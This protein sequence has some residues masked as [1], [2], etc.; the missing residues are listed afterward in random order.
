M[1]NVKIARPAFS[2]NSKLYPAQYYS[3]P[4]IAPA[5]VQ[6][7][8]GYVQQNL[9]K[10][11]QFTVK[12][13]AISPY[14]INNE[15]YMDRVRAKYG[16]SDDGTYDLYG[17]I[18][19]FIG[20]GVGAAYTLGFVKGPKS[21][22]KGN[23]IGSY[24]PKILATRNARN[25]AMAP[26]SDPNKYNLNTAIAKHKSIVIDY[27]KKVDTLNEAKKILEAKTL[28]LNNAK[29]VYANNV[30]AYENADAAYKSSDFYRSNFKG[31]SIKSKQKIAAVDNLN[32]LNKSIADS[33]Q[34][35]K[36]QADAHDLAIDSVRIAE[37]GTDIARTAL[38][39]ADAIFDSVE[40]GQKIATKSIGFVP[41]VGI[42]MDVLSLGISAMALH[43]SIQD[44]D[45]TGVW[46]NGVA[47]LLDAVALVADFF[48][49]VGD[50]VSIAASVGST[51]MTGY[52]QGRTIGRSFSPEG[53]RAQANFF[54]NIYHSIQTRPIS[55]V[56]ALLVMGGV[57]RVAR[58]G[59]ARHG[60]A[61][62]SWSRF[63]TGTGVGNIVRSST[64]MLAM[65]YMAQ[66]SSWVEEELGM[67]PDEPSQVNF[68]N[69]IGIFG[70]INDNLFGATIRKSQMA[71]ILSGDDKQTFSSF[72]K[73]SWG[74]VGSDD[75][76][77]H[78]IMFADVREAAGIDTK[79]P[80]INSVID[81]VGEML[82][83][84]QNYVEAYQITVR[85][86]ARDLST[87]ARMKPL[88]RAAE[89]VALKEAQLKDSGSTEPLKVDPI[90]DGIE[91]YLVGPEGYFRGT[92]QQRRL[93][94]RQLVE[95]LFSETDLRKGMKKVQG[96]LGDMSVITNKGQSG[97]EYKTV[98]NNGE[99][100]TK[101][102]TKLLEDT[103]ITNTYVSSKYTNVDEIAAYRTRLTELALLANNMAAGIK[104]PEEKEKLKDAAAA[105]MKRL[106]KQYGK[107]NNEE[108]VAKFIDDLGFEYKDKF[109]APLFSVSEDL[110]FHTDI[111]NDLAEIS[112]WM[113]MPVQKIARLD[114]IRKIFKVRN[115]FGR[116]KNIIMR[117][118]AKTIITHFEAFEDVDKNFD[119]KKELED[120]K[121]VTPTKTKLQEL[122]SRE[123]KSVDTVVTEQKQRMNKELETPLKIAAENE[124]L[125][126]QGEKDLEESEK[127]MEEQQKYLYTGSKTYYNDN[128]EP[129]AINNKEDAIKALEASQKFEEDNIPK[130]T[131]I[132]KYVRKHKDQLAVQQYE[133]QKI[134]AA[135]YLTVMVYKAMFHT[136]KKRMRYVLSLLSSLNTAISD[137][138]IDV[139]IATGYFKEY[140][141]ATIQRK[142]LDVR[143]EAAEN[144]K[145][146]LEKSTKAIE[147]VDKNV[148]TL[149][150]DL[151]KGEA[152]LAVLKKDANKLKAAT[153]IAV[154]RFKTEEV[155]A[156]NKL[157]F[158]KLQEAKTEQVAIHE[159]HGDLLKD[160]ARLADQ[161]EKLTFYQTTRDA[162]EALGLK[163]TKE[164]FD[165]ETMLMNNDVNQFVFD[166]KKWDE[167]T[168][169]LIESERILRK[170]GITFYYTEKYV[171]TDG[172]TKTRQTPIRFSEGYHKIP[173]GA[174]LQV[175]YK[176]SFSDAL[177]GTL[178][179]VLQ[180]ND[181]NILMN[182][183][184]KGVKNED[185]SNLTKE[186]WRGMT[187]KKRSDYVIKLLS[188]MNLTA[189]QQ[190]LIDG[191]TIIA[192]SKALSN[193][194]LETNTRTVQIEEMD[195]TV[196]RRVV[197]SNLLEDSSEFKQRYEEVFKGIKGLD[198]KLKKLR[199]EVL[200]NLDKTPQEKKILLYLI[201][202]HT[203]TFN[204]N[205]KHMYAYKYVRDN[206]MKKTTTDTETALFL[207]EDD[208]TGNVLPTFEA[209]T[210]IMEAPIKDYRTMEEALI[211]YVN[212]PMVIKIFESSKKS[213][214]HA[215]D[216][217]I[218]H[219]KELAVEQAENE[220]ERIQTAILAAPEGDIKHL[221]D[222]L[223][224]ARKKLQT[225]QEVLEKAESTY[226]DQAYVD[227][228]VTRTTETAA[229]TAQDNVV[230]DA[231]LAEV[232]KLVSE[233]A[234]RK[235]TGV[236]IFRSY[237]Q[238]KIIKHSKAYTDEKKITTPEVFIINMQQD[239][240][241]KGENY[242]DYGDS[243]IE[244]SPTRF[245]KNA[246]E[247]ESTSYYDVIKKHERSSRGHDK[248]LRQLAEYIYYTIE[249]S[250]GTVSIDADYLSKEAYHLIGLNLKTESGKLE[251]FIRRF[252]ETYKNDKTKKIILVHTD[253]SK[254]VKY[255]STKMFKRIL[256]RQTAAYA[257]KYRDT[258]LLEKYARDINGYIT[259]DGITEFSKDLAHAKPE[260]TA[261]IS[262][263][264]IIWQE[265]DGVFA[266][267]KV[268]K[269]NK[270]G[271]I[272][273][274]VDMLHDY[275]RND[276]GTLSEHYWTVSQD[277]VIKLAYGNPKM[278]SLLKAI[279][280]YNKDKESDLLLFELVRLIDNSVLED[281]KFK[282]PFV[283]S[284]YTGVKIEKG[285][286]FFTTKENTP[287]SMFEVV[288]LKKVDLLQIKKAL[289]IWKVPEELV[290]RT[291]VAYTEMLE[292]YG[293]LITYQPL[294]LRE[295]IFI[296]A[297]GTKKEWEFLQQ[298]TSIGSFYQM[299][300]L[301][302][303]L[304]DVGDEE[305]IIDRYDRYKQYLHPEIVKIYVDVNK[306]KTGILSNEHQEVLKKYGLTDTVL[307]KKEKSK[308]IF[309]TLVLDSKNIDEKTKQLVIDSIFFKDAYTGKAAY[310][311]EEVR[312]AEGKLK[313]V[314]IA[315]AGK[316]D[317]AGRAIYIEGI[318]NDY[319]EQSAAAAER[320]KSTKREK[321]TY[322]EGYKKV[323]QNEK[324]KL[325][326]YLK[327]ANDVNKLIRGKELEDNTTRFKYLLE[328][329]EKVNDLFGYYRDTDDPKQ[330]LIV[331]HAYKEDGTYE[332]ILI[333]EQSPN[334]DHNYEIK[335][336]GNPR[337]NL[338]VYDALSERSDDK[339]KIKDL[340]ET[341][342]KA[343][344]WHPYKDIVKD[345]I[346]SEDGAVV[347]V[348]RNKTSVN[349]KGETF[350]NA[351][352]GKHGEISRL[353]VSLIAALNGDKPTKT[354]SSLYTVSEDEYKYIT[355]VKKKEDLETEVVYHAKEI[356]VD[357]KKTGRYYGEQPLLVTTKGGKVLSEAYFNDLEMF[358]STATKLKDSE[359]NKYTPEEF[360][361]NLIQYAKLFNS[362]V[363]PNMAQFT[364]VPFS[365]SKRLD[366]LKKTAE[367]LDVY[368]FF[369]SVLQLHGLDINTVNLDLINKH[370]FSH[371][372]IKQD[373]QGHF[374][375]L[376]DL[377]LAVNADAYKEIENAGYLE[378]IKEALKMTQ[379]KYGSKSGLWISADHLLPKN[380]LDTL[381][382][383]T[384]KVIRVV[385]KLHSYGGRLEKNFSSAL[386]KKYSR[387]QETGLG[388]AELQNRLTLSNQLLQHEGIDPLSITNPLRDPVKNKSEFI[389]TTNLLQKSFET[390]EGNIMYVGKK[391][392]KTH[393]KKREN[394]ASLHARRKKASLNGGI[395]WELV[396]KSNNNDTKSV[397]VD[398][399]KNDAITSLAS[400]FTG[401]LEWYYKIIDATKHSPNEY[402]MYKLN[403]K[404]AMSQLN[405]NEKDLFLMM[406]FI[407]EDNAG[408]F[409]NIRVKNETQMYNLI[410]NYVVAS[411]LKNI[412]D[413]VFPSTDWMS[414][415]PMG[416]TTEQVEAEIKYK[417]NLYK[418]TNRFKPN[419]VYREF[420]EE[421]TGD[422]TNLIGA[423][424][425][426]KFSISTALS[427]IAEIAGYD[428]IETLEK[429]FDV[430]IDKLE[431]MLFNMTSK[432]FSSV[433]KKERIYLE[434]LLGR[435]DKD[436]L[437]DTVKEYIESILDNDEREAINAFVNADIYKKEFTKD[438]K[439]FAAIQRHYEK[440]ENYIKVR[441]HYNNVYSILKNKS[442]NTP[443]KTT[444]TNEEKA[445]V[446]INVWKYF[447]LNILNNDHEFMKYFLKTFLHAD[448]SDT[449]GKLLLEAM[450]IK[451]T[452]ALKRAKTFD[453]ALK[454]L[455]YYMSPQ[456]MYAF[457]HVVNTAKMLYIQTSMKDEVVSKNKWWITAWYKHTRGLVRQAQ[458]QVSNMQHMGV[459][460]GEFDSN[461][462]NAVRSE[463]DFM[464]DALTHTD[465]TNEKLR[466]VMIPMKD[467]AVTENT[468][469]AIYVRQA[470]SQYKTL[471]R[472]VQRDLYSVLF[473]NESTLSPQSNHYYM[474][475]RALNSAPMHIVSEA[476][477]TRFDQVSSTNTIYDDILRLF[478]EATVKIAGTTIKAS[479]F[480]R[481]SEIA[482][483][484]KTLKESGEYE[485][486]AGV[487]DRYIEKISTDPGRT[488]FKQADITKAITEIIKYFNRNPVLKG[489]EEVD[490]KAIVGKLLHKRLNK[491]YGIE[492]TIRDIYRYNVLT[493][494]AENDRYKRKLEHITHKLNSSK[495]DEEAIEILFGKP[496]SALEAKD[497]EEAE[498]AMVLVKSLRGLI[499]SGFTLTPEIMHD[500]YLNVTDKVSP[501]YK[502]IR[503][504]TVLFRHE[505]LVH[506]EAE[507]NVESLE[508]AL[509]NSLKDA[510]GK[511]ITRE[512]LIK[513]KEAA[514]LI[515]EQLKV[516]FEQA[517]FEYD[518][519][520]AISTDE[521]NDVYRQIL[522]RHPE[523]LEAH[524]QK[525]A[526]RFEERMKKLE[527][528]Y[529][530]LTTK[531]PEDLRNAAN[532][533]IKETKELEKFFKGFT[534][535]VVAEVKDKELTA[536]TAQYLLDTH[537]TSFD[538]LEITTHESIL[539]W[540][541]NARKLYSSMRAR[542]KINNKAIVLK[543]KDGKVVPSATDIKNYKKELEVIEKVEGAL[544]KDLDNAVFNMDDILTDVE[545]VRE[546]VL[547]FLKE[548]L[549]TYSAESK[550]EFLDTLK[551]KRVGQL[552]D[553]SKKVI[554]EKLTKRLKKSEVALAGIINELISLDEVQ[555][556]YPDSVT[557]KENISKNEKAL[558]KIKT[559]IKNT[560]ETLKAVE[561]NK[562]Y[563]MEE[564]IEKALDTYLKK[565]DIDFKNKREYLILYLS[566][567][568]NKELNEEF[569][570]QKT[571]VADKEAAMNKQEA[572]VDKYTSQLELPDKLA[573]A[574]K[575]RNE[576][577][578]RLAA[579]TRNKEAS[580]RKH[581]KAYVHGNSNLGTYKNLYYVPKV[582]DYEEQDRRI[583]DQI[584]DDTCGI[585]DCGSDQNKADLIRKIKSAGDYDIHNPLVD[586]LI[587]RMNY[588]AQTGKTKDDEFFVF[589]METVKHEGVDIPYQMT[590]LHNQKGGKLTIYNVYFNSIGFHRTAGEETKTIQGFKQALFQMYA[591]RVERGKST[592]RK[593]YALTENE[594]ETLTKKANDDAEAVIRKVGRQK[595]NQAFIKT[596]MHIFTH[597]N[598][599]KIPVVTHAGERFDMPNYSN[600]IK[601]YANNLLSNLYYSYIRDKDP[602]EIME[603]FQVSSYGEL[604]DVG[605]A[606]KSDEII[607]AMNDDMVGT[608]KKIKKGEQIT[609][610]EIEQ[611]RKLN[612]AILRVYISKHIKTLEE[613][614]GITLDQ[615]VKKE[616]FNPLN[617]QLV[618]TRDI[619]SSWV[620][621]SIADRASLRQSLI[622]YYVEGVQFQERVDARHDYRDEVTAKVDE[623]L[624][625]FERMY[626]NI[627][628]K[629][630]P[631][632]YDYSDKILSRRQQVVDSVI[633]G[634]IEKGDPIEWNPR[635]LL[636]SYITQKESLIGSREILETLTDDGMKQTVEALER[637]QKYLDA[638]IARIDAK[639]IEVTS[640]I[641]EH[642]I[643][644][645][646]YL[647]D[648][649]KFVKN[650]QYNSNQ[651]Y[652]QMREVLSSTNIRLYNAGKNATVNTVTESMLNHGLVQTLK[653]INTTVTQLE[654]LVNVAKKAIFLAEQNKKVTLT[655]E[656]TDAAVTEAGAFKLEWLKFTKQE[657]L[658]EA[659]KQLG[660]RLVEQQKILQDLQDHDVYEKL[661]LKKQMD[662]SISKIYKAQRSTLD[663]YIEEYKR[664]HKIYQDKYDLKLVVLPDDG[665]KAT[666]PEFK[667]YK[668]A[669]KTETD[670]IKTALI[671]AAKTTVDK[672]LLQ[673]PDLKRLLSLISEDGLI[674]KQVESLHIYKED[675][676]N[677]YRMYRP[678]LIAGVEESIRNINN[679]IITISDLKLGDTVNTILSV[680]NA[681]VQ[682]LLSSVRKGAMYQEDITARSILSV[683]SRR[684]KTTDE[685]SEEELN[686]AAKK[687]LDKGFLDGV[688]DPWA[689]R[690]HDNILKH[691]N[692]K[693]LMLKED[694]IF[695]K[696]AVNED[697][698][699]NIILNFYD[700]TSRVSQQ[701]IISTDNPTNVRFNIAYY[702]RRANAP[703]S[704]VGKIEL[705]KI[706]HKRYIYDE[707]GNATAIKL[708]VEE[709]LK[710]FYKNHTA[711]KGITG[712]SVY[713]VDGKDKSLESIERLLKFYNDEI[714]PNLKNYF[715]KGEHDKMTVEEKNLRF[716]K[717]FGSALNK[718]IDHQQLH[719]KHLDVIDMTKQTENMF[720][721][722]IKVTRTLSGRSSFKDVAGVYQGLSDALLSEY[723]AMQPGKIL[724]LID[725]EFSTTYILKYDDEQLL[726]KNI[727][728]YNVSEGSMGASFSERSPLSTHLPF[729][730]NINAI[731]IMLPNPKHYFSYNSTGITNAL[732]LAEDAMKEKPKDYVS[733]LMSNFD[734]LMPE[735]VSGVYDWK[736]PKVFIVD[737][738]TRNNKQITTLDKVK[739]TD[740]IKITYN[741]ATIKRLRELLGTNESNPFIPNVVSKEDLYQY[742]QDRLHKRGINLTVT[743]ANDVRAYEDTIL[744]D[745]ED[746]KALGWGEAYKT[747]LGSAY[748]F[749]GAVKLIKGLR[750]NYGSTFVASAASV[751]KRGAYGALIEMVMSN[752]KEAYKN[753]SEATGLMKE[754]IN[755]YNKPNSTIHKY[756]KLDGDFAIVK[757]NVDYADFFKD[758]TLFG[759]LKP[760]ESAE[761][762]LNRIFKE[763]L[764]PSIVNN[765]TY[766][767][768]KGKDLIKVA[769][770]GD[771]GWQG[772]L[773]VFADAEKITDKVAKE[774]SLRNFGG[775]TTAQVD[776][777]GTV[778]NGAMLSISVLYPM[779]AK[780]K[781]MNWSKAFFDEDDATKAMLNNPKAQEYADISIGGIEYI[782]KKYGVKH[783]KKIGT[784][785]VGATIL[786]MED[787]VNVNIIDY[788]K[789]YITYDH[790]FV[791]ELKVYTSLLQDISIRKAEL[792]QKIR[793][794]AH[795]RLV[796]KNGVLNGGIFRKHFGGRQQVV[797]NTSLK[798][799]T[800]ITNDNIWFNNIKQDPTWLDKEPYDIEEFKKEILNHTYD[801]DGLKKTWKITEDAY[802]LTVKEE[803]AKDV[804]LL[805]SRNGI[806]KNKEYPNVLTIKTNRVDGTKTF[807]IPKNVERVFGY[808]LTMRHPVQDY[809]AVSLIKIIGYHDHD[810]LEADKYSYLR[811][812]ADNDGDALGM[813]SI[814]KS[815][816]EHLKELDASKESFYDAD[817]FDRV[818]KDVM[819]T[820]TTE[821][822]SYIRNAEGLYM[823]K[824]FNKVENIS[825]ASSNVGKF[826]FEQ[827]V[828]NKGEKKRIRKMLTTSE[829]YILGFEDIN[830]EQQIVN[831]SKTEELLKIYPKAEEE[832]LSDEQLLRTY[833]NAYIRRL[834]GGYD[835][836]FKTGK[837]IESS[838]NPLFAFNTNQGYASM[839]SMTALLKDNKI[840][841]NIIARYAFSKAID[842]G[843]RKP[844]D[845]IELTSAHVYQMYAWLDKVDQEQLQ[846][847]YAM[848]TADKKVN[849]LSTIGVFLKS[850][851]EE[852][853]R[854][855]KEIM[856]NKIL[857]K[858]AQGTMER[859]AGSKIGI[860][861]FGGNRKSQFI[862]SMIMRFGTIN[863][864][865]AGKIWDIVGAYGLGGAITPITLLHSILGGTFRANLHTYLEL[866]LEDF[867]EKAVAEAQ[868]THIYENKEHTLAE[869]IKKTTGISDPEKAAKEFIEDVA[870]IVYNAHKQSNSAIEVFSNLAE[871]LGGKNKEYTIHRFLNE[872]FIN[873]AYLLPTVKYLK[874]HAKD[875]YTENELAW[876]KIQFFGA[877]KQ[878]ANNFFNNA[879]KNKDL[880]ETVKKF[881]EDY[882]NEHIIGRR[883]FT[884]ASNDATEVIGV[885]KHYGSDLDITRWISSYV[886]RVTEDANKHRIRR[887]NLDNQ[888]AY[889]NY[890]VA[891]DRNIFKDN[892]DLEIHDEEYTKLVAAFGEGSPRTTLKDSYRSEEEGRN[893]LE[894]I[895]I[896]NFNI[897]LLGR[898][899][900]DEIIT[901]RIKGAIQN[902]VDSF[903]GVNINDPV[904]LEKAAIK[905]EPYAKVLTTFNVVGYKLRNF[906][907]DYIF[908]YTYINNKLAQEGRELI[909][910]DKRD[911]IVNNSIGV[912]E[913][914]YKMSTRINRLKYEKQLKD[915]APLTNKFLQS[916]TDLDTEYY[917]IDSEGS[918]SR[919]GDKS[920]KNDFVPSNKVH[921]HFV[922]DAISIIG[923]ARDLMINE[924]SESMT[925]K[926]TKLFEV[927]LKEMELDI[928]DK[929]HTFE[930]A[931]RL[932][933]AEYD[934]L[935]IAYYKQTKQKEALKTEP[936]G[937][938]EDKKRSAVY[939]QVTNIE[940]FKKDLL[941]L[942][943]S[944]TEYHKNIL[945]LK[946]LEKELNS[947]KNIKKNLIANKQRFENIKVNL[948]KL[949]SI[950]KEIESINKQIKEVDESIADIKETVVQY[951]FNESFNELVPL[952]HTKDGSTIRSMY[953]YTQPRYLGKEDLEEFSH[954]L[955][956]QMHYKLSPFLNTLPAFP[957][958]DPKSK[959]AFDWKEMYKW[960]VSRYDQRRLVIIRQG[961]NN[962]GLLKRLTD[963]MYTEVELL[964]KGKVIK[965]S[966]KLFNTPDEF[967]EHMKEV[968]KDSKKQ[969]GFKFNQTPYS[970]ISLDVELKDFITPTM[971]E[972]DIKNWETLKYI[973]EQIQKDPTKSYFIGFVSVNDIMDTYEQTYMP[974]SYDGNPL[975][976]SLIWFMYKSSKLIQRFSLGFIIRNWVDTW[977]QLYSEAQQK[978]GVI[979]AILK[980]PE[981]IGLMK[982]VHEIR[983]IYKRVSLDRTLYLTVFKSHYETIN[984]IITSGR[985]ITKENEITINK[986]LALIK[987]ILESYRD[988]QLAPNEFSSH[989]HKKQIQSEE[990]IR[991][992]NLVIKDTEKDIT[993]L[994]RPS[995]LMLLESTVR[996]M[997]RMKFAEYFVMYDQLRDAFDG[998]SLYQSKNK[999][1000][1001][1002]DLKKRYE[1003]DWEDFKMDLF[1004]ISAFMQTNAQI[1005][1006]YQ[1007]EQSTVIKKTLET[1008][1009]RPDL[1010]IEE[1011]YEAFSRAITK[1012]LKDTSLT[1013]WQAMGR[1014]VGAL[1015]PKNKLKG[1016]SAVYNWMTSETENAGRVA[1017]YILDKH[1018]H[1019]LTFEQS[1020]NKSLTRFFNYG[1021][1022]S[1023][1024]E[1025][1026]MMLADI[1027]YLSFPIRSINNWINRL[1028]DPRYVRFLSDMIDGVYGQYTDEN[1029]QYDEF[1030]QYQIENGW[1031]P[1032]A[1033]GVGLRLGNGAFDVAQL[1034]T[1035]PLQQIEQRR[1036]PV[1037][1038]MI[1039][1040][1041]GDYLISEERN[1042]E[1043]L[1044]SDVI[1045]SSASVGFAARVL[1046]NLGVVSEDVRSAASQVP[1047]IRD[1048]VKTKTP[1049]NAVQGFSKASTGFYWYDN[1050]SEFKKYTPK[1051]YDYSQGNGR[1052]KYYENIYK[1053]WFNKWGKMR[1054]PKVDPYSLVKD[1055]HWKNYVRWRQQRYMNR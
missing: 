760:G 222:A 459:F 622:D 644:K 598:I 86:R 37:K 625:K 354:V 143:Q 667:N 317:K 477:A 836:F 617:G 582:V 736:N 496:M 320:A 103:F 922:Q 624:S 534:A 329:P 861:S 348:T 185:G 958:N 651:L 599:N 941:G 491:R 925:E 965:K 1022:R 169:T 777:T 885:A 137:E 409:E 507:K 241:D 750:T 891:M 532:A 512:Q 945:E 64:T 458:T 516:E 720:L 961:E 689:V 6:G 327:A 681:K 878:E 737:K 22:L 156:S 803:N 232:E 439:V 807:I 162:K 828:N 339:E 1000:Y 180:L 115:A 785:D 1032:I 611:V 1035:D 561:A 668:N 211:D 141:N 531:Y 347:L 1034:L 277:V 966:K 683:V 61:G 933:M 783:S 420:P 1006:E 128:K 258:K 846:K 587:T 804:E 833:V 338:R 93:F 91:E 571:I 865:A 779:L 538:Y 604:D 492:V 997:G 591:D 909:H 430:V 900:A 973:F 1045:R 1049:K 502:D 857:S 838:T 405:A 73:S 701:I 649:I 717:V 419:E 445:Q 980:L 855:R 307:N 504:D 691:N 158:K 424:E 953:N 819:L 763:L 784:W 433:Y 678:I 563:T 302:A 541:T 164:D 548:I 124:A 473:V 252:S 830:L 944:R 1029:G 238:V 375:D 556:F 426:M 811:A 46:I 186:Q 372:F 432:D 659:K 67:N 369:L 722:Y 237:N 656:E 395:F 652:R 443:I 572:L 490:I 813:I 999:T 87:E 854:V 451:D 106:E 796:G 493:A 928:F 293:D 429:N 931:L 988:A 890:S 886:Y 812:G 694:T 5:S 134:A 876:L 361:N 330:E 145:K 542:Q 272:L 88:D 383:L 837:L 322:T 112:M 607:K 672:L 729:K 564:L 449:G 192:I 415:N 610:S 151:T 889:L 648:L 937:S 740:E 49:G 983:S 950:K 993:V 380:F 663:G 960:Y 301:S 555:K 159:K 274:R 609:K 637:K 509:M 851:K 34:A 191:P 387:E 216:V 686:T 57:N 863:K 13:M 987:N 165:T 921:Q 511:T 1011:S 669:L 793:R 732:Y 10:Q 845:F 244:I 871:A 934:T 859:V 696:I 1002:N 214:E 948:N 333:E 718:T 856:T 332:Y 589:D 727:D 1021:H 650:L 114:N 684:E 133:A 842:E 621:A 688:K 220:I 677:F 567:D 906:V 893:N 816:Y 636:D 43:K 825:I 781:A 343:L 7:K 113:F 500:V 873:E 968:T 554:I 978:Y 724:N 675:K 974:F 882:L 601:R 896:D 196:L 559:V 936:R 253:K 31:T 847:D 790:E 304:R 28:D 566:G 764:K 864:D 255:N 951:V 849:V 956:M 105:T 712:E 495:T 897:Q 829:I 136:T 641:D 300:S 155:E 84:P 310:T 58:I 569:E 708:N 3:R 69:G 89:V 1041:V 48:P 1031:V 129:V 1053:D 860:E 565:Y 227:S 362:R 880:T 734:Y 236:R 744:M 247:T 356:E 957:N 65:R 627:M 336:Q 767:I 731:R 1005:D 773:Y 45:T 1024:L 962:E 623:L 268:A 125:I 666:D 466:H 233:E 41:V 368:Y 920:D 700:Q 18:G 537:K 144:N 265:A 550:Q 693:A 1039:S 757:P 234:Y 774:A 632:I 747:W 1036:S 484:I 642:N 71:S 745:Y 969:K 1014:N 452:A 1026:N 231:V 447:N 685:M 826:M 939:K 331:A 239:L 80:I 970:G 60:G 768:R 690:L 440:N 400:F 946:D 8:P 256:F 1054:K 181:T 707:E 345:V 315:L 955:L 994:K 756:V 742:Q 1012:E 791:D 195:E 535:K 576:S 772:K 692:K 152:E 178:F 197:M 148:A 613:E 831:G 506:K 523:L 173:K 844:T 596:Y 902:F 334:G 834:T 795:V 135:D 615:D 595:N 1028:T 515:H 870:E 130:G 335:N 206:V 884:Q 991:K 318:D 762:R 605:D 40:I 436:N 483:T 374:F 250:K 975:I 33:K 478:G 954:S 285:E 679:S 938:A 182:G 894:A 913:I 154:N 245:F 903:K 1027:P 313:K 208:L 194:Q 759:V 321:V 422:F 753:P 808:V 398:L 427:I 743:F 952:L 543:D 212:S 728:V 600:F 205:F 662:E 964:K 127:L 50:L 160:R 174:S 72:F 2:A 280:S 940:R 1019:N 821:D 719:L 705:P 588:M 716:D 932:L 117:N 520:K 868:K 887:T 120:L 246:G 480:F 319:I 337:N 676:E 243:R 872:S 203:E 628:L 645:D 766:E 908:N 266:D 460:Q 735:K 822:A 725:P 1046:S 749:K 378:A 911:S 634:V 544:E 674:S 702:Y 590:I 289:S 388:L 788:V 202:T 815:Q 1052:Y 248:S 592:D 24:N 199:T 425:G 311:K 44:G 995:N 9:V 423:P 835:N 711:K 393:E 98:K 985:V 915:I 364:R 291:E 150:N 665:I 866:S 549:A 350:V 183:I 905:A 802:R 193:I 79:V 391:L 769:G 1023:P 392:Y 792:N 21:W 898:V 972:I 630:K 481:V 359:G 36:V 782:L 413:V 577:Q 175:S 221:E 635:E 479:D 47:T 730:H 748:G 640:K 1042:Q 367:S 95:A 817:Y 524:L 341:I 758:T 297:G 919:R 1018:L 474:L 805:L 514:A 204:Y 1033:G 907:N 85:S 101:L 417:E 820:D 765:H 303:H 223:E 1020:V 522:I 824:A 895:T 503:T 38:K 877:N 261:L 294:D 242:R 11:F 434:K 661:L 63:F 428:K 1016:I 51:A 981:I 959:D 379:K 229:Q 513:L 1048:A 545:S 526:T 26:K 59:A 485:L 462:I 901:K 138:T 259:Q 521:K 778:I 618:K 278:Y 149:S 560:E 187:I 349:K 787:K 448:D 594:I 108:L 963:M 295:D 357:G 406:H 226:Y 1004:E 66:A 176:T 1007:E 401:K 153:E 296:K 82:V 579:A 800:G 75:R 631:I 450:G 703:L 996:F 290:A 619:V 671:S 469:K 109:I 198:D 580:E 832:L 658:D 270:L 97:G 557:T 869:L 435:D 843:L 340:K 92:A 657:E 935:R 647:T 342:N 721:E 324:I 733:N 370:F 394:D 1013:F 715:A 384:G 184:I 558:E 1010:D 536:E 814:V 107:H 254:H 519:F 78:S 904:Q 529:K 839:D 923:T 377:K 487:Y 575:E 540:L 292:E 508:N 263:R 552:T 441:E 224:S 695:S 314:E 917:Y 486:W 104:T 574:I 273:K 593:K 497:K 179:D 39:G 976:E 167:N 998:V 499:A 131:S 761:D 539:E 862:A 547:P 979:G 614:M 407:L 168:E 562:E 699:R 306:N 533:Q 581:E 23:F 926:E 1047:V 201:E 346:L 282:T 467:V 883:E 653:E 352:K 704:G 53:M 70:D 344:I 739:D 438:P 287:V 275:E 912:M 914:L 1038:R 228:V 874:H 1040:A 230:K 553:A 1003:D 827:Y 698:S 142:E 264:Q 444:R 682:E 806:I 365:A 713:K 437:P 267:A 1055:I 551:S 76:L 612:Q 801:N 262:A 207:D 848:F 90:K 213:I 858:M 726:A 385:K 404:E 505:S 489:L 281:Y 470:E 971:K 83:D 992:L 916:D 1:S 166:K 188:N 775:I 251:Y 257:Q 249:G 225:A 655:V 463:T 102:I 146:Y 586:T 751:I 472:S 754:L 81:V 597:A 121:K 464:F 1001:M 399:E 454:G 1009:L 403:L 660:I 157:I 20:A 797:A 177:Y 1025:M 881:S 850:S 299:L 626:H 794:E 603:R 638:D 288:F 271:S 55:T 116:F 501:L 879:K 892:P 989:I 279:M 235:A 390:N 984:E 947:K 389:K 77:F 163:W 68:T 585:G 949:A 15:K 840:K 353:R 606:K 461:I 414:V 147:A 110:R 119:A 99:M 396:K 568:T 455:W 172:K 670:K 771:S 741:E 25:V 351:E 189:E 284:D 1050:A 852:D 123:P 977:N 410:T 456:A 260:D 42:G 578:Q 799:G 56:S 482:E 468:A 888:R 1008:M 687:V 990:I 823:P 35:I 360:I 633:G 967:I 54:E 29:A 616:L 94:W 471:A 139:I 215:K 528:S 646:E 32:N 530:T 798:M 776:E 200:E 16:F 780:S 602:K 363:V 875:K 752:F 488:D 52:Y 910:F 709:T 475:T 517:Q 714:V 122:I 308:I 371:R 841:K 584:V 325:Q 240:F 629:N 19:G 190:A 680:T 510:D 697:G 809:N 298:H 328:H 323:L 218:Y 431:D 620:I 746:A 305:N 312:K 421:L 518:V 283:I 1037:G 494:R 373:E 527:A 4:A 418:D 457:V 96:M 12:Q 376:E 309:A 416:K 210:K 118:S 664:L 1015:N 30:K 639:M 918:I 1044:L 853:V 786:N 755:E 929:P 355:S 942:A 867:K 710:D 546:L 982:N 570:T 316:K 789:E 810:G 573:E 924:L 111:A 276:V 62:T 583:L 100:N 411:Y 140:I 358:A 706:A 654:T 170:A 899:H 286:V 171:G 927:A 27:N 673:E 217:A 74:D 17:H 412:R 986:K 402:N 608:L 498:E 219:A 1051:Q 930:E 386:N 126:K 14:S 442:H 397:M 1017:G 1030:M 132:R 1043:K 643:A 446:T 366:E 770:T 326:N 381:E 818:D 209:V 476:Y 453:D 408:I 161:I 382:S 525:Q 943:Q 723:N 738:K 269:S 465:R